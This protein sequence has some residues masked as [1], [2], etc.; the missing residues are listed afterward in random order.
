MARL[1]EIGAIE[2]GE[3]LRI[4]RVSVKKTQ[5]EIAG[6]L[7]VSRPTMISIEKGQRKIRLDELHMVAPVLGI[8][9]NK[10]LARDAVH[11]D[12]FA[13]FR[14]ANADQDEAA[15][16]IRLLNKLASASVELERILGINF[17]PSYPPEQPISQGSV[18]R[19]AEEAAMSLRHR[20]GL[21]H[22]PIS[23]IVSL[24]EGELGIRV[25][26]RSLPSK[27]SGLFAFD[28]LVGACILLNAN[29]PWERRALTAAHETGHFVSDRSSVD[30][31]EIDELA[32]SQEERFANAFSFAF[33][34]PPIGVRRKFKE[35][36]EADNRFTPRHLI[37]MAHTF[38]VSPEAMCRYMER[39]E[40]LPGGTFD[41][42]KE[43]GFDRQFIRGI[44]GDLAPS[45]N[46]LPTTPRLAQLA[47]SAYRRGLVSEGQL[48]RM[49]ELDRI[50]VRRLL[51]TFGGSEE[52]E[53]AI[54][55]S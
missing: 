23:D 16:S 3:R 34:M 43:R 49:L 38:H 47:S 26:I 44:V 17:S 9:V 20:L 40:L 10:F 13:R 6:V 12:L 32:T 41:S 53:F 42:M 29:H 39:L 27:V 33:M 51:D 7:G 37:L 24:I 31:L 19:Q 14:K 15:S 52:D 18:E 25:F 50:E 35:L 55:L 4:A 36:A 30:V 54:P 45:S 5:D 46:A 8:S 22:A 48:A 2:I 11:V 28:P 21:G 1:E